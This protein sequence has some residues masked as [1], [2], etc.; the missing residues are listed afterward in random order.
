MIF[1]TIVHG[2]SSK[3]YFRSISPQ[4]GKHCDLGHITDPARRRLLREDAPILNLS[5]QQTSLAFELMVRPNNRAHIVGPGEYQLD[6]LVAAENAR[7][8][9]KT[10]SLS[11]RGT[12]DA[13]ETRMLRDGIGVSVL[14]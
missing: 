10:L 13:D 5:D 6:I 4:M 8:M 1:I 12:W 11:I 3:I 7:P 9:T 2:G 14:G